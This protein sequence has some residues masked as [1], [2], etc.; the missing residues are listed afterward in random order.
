MTSCVFSLF[1]L[2][3]LCSSITA[4]GPTG[5]KVRIT[6]RV[7][8]FLKDYG[9]KYLKELVNKPFQDFQLQS[10]SK[11]YIKQFTLTR[12]DVEHNKV[13]VRFQPGS[14]LQ[15]EF[16]D[17]SFTAE[18]QREIC[19]FNEA[20]LKGPA[21]ITGERVG[22]TI[23]VKLIQKQGHLSVEIPPGDDYCKTQAESVHVELTGIT[24]SLL[25]AVQLTGVFQYMFNNLFCPAI[26]YFAVP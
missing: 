16:K 25:N 15:F 17:L 6:D 7:P 3:S 22:V 10:G 14:G 19:I 1:F 26:R 12:L 23:G 21:V 24:G 18:F 8:E 5:L 2:L 20:F 11:C 13:N 9:L 4:N